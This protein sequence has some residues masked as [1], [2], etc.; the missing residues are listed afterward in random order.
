MI[1][2]KI[3]KAYTTVTTVDFRV[4]LREH[5]GGIR[6]MPPLCL[7]KRTE[8]IR[9]LKSIVYI[10]ECHRASA[11]ADCLSHEQQFARISVFHERRIQP[12][13]YFVAT[14]SVYNTDLLQS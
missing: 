10:P 9:V 2:A 13:M 7:R 4:I 11:V 3:R 12:T 8:K 14:L 6:R 5:K 1:K